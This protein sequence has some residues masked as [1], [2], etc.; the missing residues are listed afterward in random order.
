MTSI[1]PAPLRAA[2]ADRVTGE[3]S[4]AGARIA[5]QAAGALIVHHPEARCFS[6]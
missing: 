4:E 2:L 3:L 6:A 5:R 1:G